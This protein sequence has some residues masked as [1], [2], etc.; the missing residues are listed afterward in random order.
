VSQ[1]RAAVQLLTVAPAHA[2]TIADCMRDAHGKEPGMSRQELRAYCT[3]AV[4]RWHD[5]M[6]AYAKA[7]PDSDRVTANE[8]CK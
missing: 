8:H 6:F 1:N 7:H 4:R 2:E 5:C 3:P